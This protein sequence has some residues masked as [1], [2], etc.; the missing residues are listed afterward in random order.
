MSL[1]MNS[2]WSRIHHSTLWSHLITSKKIRKFKGSRTWLILLIHQWM[3]IFKVHFMNWISFCF[4]FRAIYFPS[5]LQFKLCFYFFLLEE[6]INQNLR[7]KY[8]K[9]MIF[10]ALFLTSLWV[11]LNKNNSRWGLN[12]KSSKKKISNKCEQKI[13]LMIW[14]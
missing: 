4:I 9:F 14:L 11:F 2:N 3:N 10:P 12:Y 6:W 5:T 1:L 7:K 8:S 13:M